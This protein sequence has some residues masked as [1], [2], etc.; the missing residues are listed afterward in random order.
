MG[1][2]LRVA[3]PVGAPIGMCAIRGSE[4][5]QL[6]I[7]PSGRGTGIATALLSDAEHRMAS[8]GET[9]AFLDCLI[10]NEP[11]KRFYTRNGWIEQGVEVA[12][13]DAQN[14]L[15]ELPC[16]IFRKTLNYSST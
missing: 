6:F 13:L 10:E 14:G 2:L 4:L 5:H 7:A 15:F 16:L 12:Q 9:S 8:A 11:A 1:D 3:G